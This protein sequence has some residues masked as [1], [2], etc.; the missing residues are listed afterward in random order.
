MDSAQRA[1]HDRIVSGPRG[2]IQGPLRAAL[3]NAELADKWQALGALL[4][5]GTTLPPRLS[6]IAILVTGRA[7]RSPFEWYAHRIEGEKA[8]LEPAFLEALLAQTEPPGMS[9]DDA[10]VWRYAVELNRHKSVSDATYAAALERFGART[11]VELTA[12]IGYYTMVAM[13]LNCHEIPLPEGVQPAFPLP[14][15]EELR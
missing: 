10:L 13:T 7:C 2:K 12:L 11:V 14:Q 1:V 6:E 3:Y 5:Y 8:G 9:G 15:Q 4:R